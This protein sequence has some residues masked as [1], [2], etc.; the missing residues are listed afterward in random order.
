MNKVIQ[1]LNGIYGVVYGGGLFLNPQ[2]LEWLEY[3]VY[4][5]GKYHMLCRQFAKDAHEKRFAIKPKAHWAQHFADQC[6]MINL[7]WH[8]N[9]GDESFLAKAVK[10]WR[11]SVSGKY[12]KTV[13]LTV[14]VKYLLYMSLIL[15]L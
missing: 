1:S 10:M 8:Q 7:R 14:L 11:S 2:E 5:L 4:K 9:Y 13:Q 3:H 15:E 6:S 12:H